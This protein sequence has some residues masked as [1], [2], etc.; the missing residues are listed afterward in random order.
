MKLFTVGYGRWPT[1]TRMDRLIAALKDAG[2]TIL[3]DARH[4]PCA[5][6][7]SPTSHYGPHDWNLQAGATGIA[8]ILQ[9]HEIRYRWLVE[10][11]NPQKTDHA[12]A[13]LRKHLASADEK[14]PVN[15]GLALLAEILNES[16]P[17][18]LLCACADWRT[19]H[20]TVIAEAMRERF[21]DLG[22]E[23][24]HV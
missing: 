15:R 12:M 18:A 24:V 2:V 1:A 10:L 19:C 22:I 11:G 7:L 13:V 14:W 3:I 9:S 23:V 21:P 20:R 17:C 6:Q 4:S 8:A 5:S 16:R